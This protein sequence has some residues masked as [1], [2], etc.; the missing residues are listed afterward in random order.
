[1][2]YETL[3]L[4]VFL[5]CAALTAIAMLT[6][7]SLWG[8]QRTHAV[9]QM[10]DEGGMDPAHEARRQFDVRFHLVG[11]AFLVCEVALLFLYPWAV[12]NKHAQ[13]I[14][15]LGGSVRAVVFVEVLVFTALLG[16]GLMY[17]WRKGVFR[18]R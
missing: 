4:L 2:S 11:I 1:M 7:G 14:A 3:P 17:A 18:W 5:G 16:C 15:A 12:A 10:P 13:G 8:P 9:K 6:V